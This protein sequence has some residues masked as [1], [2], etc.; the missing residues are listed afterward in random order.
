MYKG[1]SILSEQK[2]ISTLSDEEVLSLIKHVC[3]VGL[4][5]IVDA[6][7]ELD[8]GHDLDFIHSQLDSAARAL[9]LIFELSSGFRD[10]QD[11]FEHLFDIARITYDE[12]RTFDNPEDSMEY[13]LRRYIESKQD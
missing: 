6:L 2:N 13:R 4:I 5:N 1:G 8:S 3:P 11:L 10:K 12:E 7:Q 9:I